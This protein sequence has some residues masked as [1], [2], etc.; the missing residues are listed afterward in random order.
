MTPLHVE[1]SGTG[2]PVVFLHSSGLSGR[3]WRRLAQ[4]V[5]GRGL[6]AIVPDLTGH[7]ASPPWPALQPFSFRTDVD[8][9]VALLESHGPA[10]VVGHSYG[11]F[12]G[13]IAALA[14][15]RSIRSMVLFEPVAFGTLDAEADVDAT[16]TLKRVGRWGPSAA[17]QE[18]YLTTFVDFWGGDGAWKALRE[19]ARDEF[20]RVG[21]VLSEGV[22]TLTE[23][24]TPASAYRSIAVPVRLLTG[25]TSPVAARRVA[26]RLGDAIAGASVVVVPGAGHMAPLT[27][28]ALV[29]G[30]ILEVLAP[31]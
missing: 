14:T 18:H 16:D 4:E 9:V 12:V 27:H 10:H 2:P 22:R 29:N 21:W 17:E 23:D 25:E 19:E 31:G 30:K 3:Q 8:A 7:G 5:T 28:A 24:K 6:R 26:H 15:P 11:A 1:T 20:R 13:L